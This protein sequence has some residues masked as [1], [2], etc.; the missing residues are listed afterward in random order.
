MPLRDQRRS[1]CTLFTISHVT[2]SSCDF[3]FSGLKTATWQLIER[4]DTSLEDVRANIA[5]SFQATVAR[6][7]ITRTLRA[8]V[9]CDRH[10]SVT[11]TAVVISGGVACNTYIRH[12]LQAAVTK[13]YDGDIP[14]V[15]PSPDLCADNGK[16]IAWTGV[17]YLLGIAAG[18]LSS[19]HIRPSNGPSAAQSQYTLSR[20]PLGIDWRGAVTA[21]HI[22][23]RR[24]SKPH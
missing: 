20:W 18:R 24:P 1:C 9:F 2:V 19:E 21:S 3:S 11:P 13:A 16:M 5:A 6:H 22:P 10:L 12:E 17:E 23:L 15:W 14:T 7:L 8:L 4:E